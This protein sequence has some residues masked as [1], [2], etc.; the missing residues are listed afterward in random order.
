MNNM[1]L[2]KRLI[3]QQGLQ[4]IFTNHCRVNH[5]VQVWRICQKLV[6][7]KQ[8]IA[9]ISEYN[10]FNL[11]V[12]NVS[13]ELVGLIL[14]HD[15]NTSCYIPITHS[16]K[17]LTNTELTLSHSAK[18]PIHSSNSFNSL[19]PLAHLHPQIAHVANMGPT[20]VLSAPDGPHIGPMNLAIR[21][22]L[23]PPPTHTF[24]ISAPSPATHLPTLHSIRPLTHPLISYLTSQLCSLSHHYTVN[25]FQISGGPDYVYKLTLELKV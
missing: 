7:Y 4:S 13:A 15:T 6:K 19:N 18:S 1:P 3:D 11:L 24:S 8:N 23:D 21:D 9:S 10:S 2:Y 25:Y 5:S 14:S 22:P 12:F 20:W 17:L 16:P